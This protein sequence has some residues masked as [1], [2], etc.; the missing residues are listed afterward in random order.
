MLRSISIN[1]ILLILCTVSVLSQTEERHLE[2]LKHKIELA[3]V[4]ITNLDNPVNINLTNSSLSNLL[5][6]IA[7]VHNLNIHVEESLSSIHLVNNFENVKI[8]DLLY[9]LAKQYNLDISFS[10]NIISISNYTPPLSPQKE[11]EILADYNIDSKKISLDLNNDPLFKVFRKISD[12]TGKNLLYAPGMENIPLTIYIK[13]VPIEAALNKLAL[14]NNLNVNLSKDGF[15]FFNTNQSSEDQA[16]KI[17]DQSNDFQYK[18]LDAYHQKLKVNFRDIAAET[19]ILQLAKELKLNI[20]LASS[21]SALGTITFNSEEVTYDQLL[22]YIF[23]NGTSSSSNQNRENSSTAYQETYT[24]QYTYKKENNIYFFGTENQLLLKRVS[25]IPLLHRSINLMADPQSNF[26]LQN[27]GLNMTRTNFNSF[28]SN[29]E[30]NSNSSNQN[31]YNQDRYYHSNSSSQSNS[32][33]I[34]VLFPSEIKQGLEI[35]VDKELNSFIVQGS[36]TKIRAFKKFIE[37]IDKPVPVILIEVMILEVNKTS[38][39]ETGVSFGLGEKSI[40][41]KGQVFPNTDLQLGASTVNKIIGNFDSFGSLN[42]GKVVPEFYMNVKAMEA[43]G[44][45]KILSTPKLSTL[46]GHKAH[47]SNGETTYYA[48]TSQNFYGSQITQ[49]SEITNYYPINAELAIEILPFVAG[50]GQVTMEINVSQASFNGERI[51]ENAPPGMN[52]REF[53]SIIRMQN[54]DVAILGGIEEKTKDDSG[55]GVPLL[56]RIPL[57][58]WLFSSRRREDSNKKLNILIKPTVI[59]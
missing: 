25:R 28:N 14:T 7:K 52:S 48:V 19:I 22:S 5:L 30:Y 43:N 50:D 17:V 1:I 37:T 16:I 10:G 24:K 36:A 35:K 11:K 15:F 49:T 46:N 57:I 26:G 53:S 40:E 32:E 44:N 58:K 13:E 6:A 4:E 23:S 56:A 38:L 29:S 21:L 12:E 34:N 8:K 41:T 2:N 54:Q 18:I 3:S 27:T 33:T 55:N 31:N 20:F 42:L 47:L 45:L 39:V 9:Y 59:Y 51:E